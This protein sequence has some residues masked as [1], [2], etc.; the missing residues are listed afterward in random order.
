MGVCVTLI[1][2][3]HIGMSCRLLLFL[4]LFVTKITDSS[5][6]SCPIDPWQIILQGGGT[7]PRSGSRTADRLHASLFIKWGGW[8]VTGDQQELTPLRR[9]LP[10][11]LLRNLP[12]NRPDLSGDQVP[13]LVNRLCS[14]S[15]TIFPFFLQPISFLPLFRSIRSRYWT[16]AYEKIPTRNDV[17]NRTYSLKETI[18]YS[19]CGTL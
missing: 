12:W 15:Y 10:L 16:R 5:H 9:T 1:G 14:G 2:Q 11:R 18:T 17:E 13:G 4:I 6:C 3:W 8:P 19:H 7:A